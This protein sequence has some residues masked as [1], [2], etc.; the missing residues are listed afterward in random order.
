MGIR[1]PV[2]RRSALLGATG[3]VAASGLERSIPSV[4]LS[5]ARAQSMKPKMATEIP[6]EITT[7]D[8]WRRGSVL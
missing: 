7:P 6:P 4:L 1:D 5:P 2:T 3:L 8:A